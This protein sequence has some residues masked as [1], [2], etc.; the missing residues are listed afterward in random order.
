MGAHAPLVKDS[1]FLKTIADSNSRC[2]VVGRNSPS[3]GFGSHNFLAVV[4][5]I[6]KGWGD[7]KYILPGALTPGLLVFLT[8]I[9]FKITIQSLELV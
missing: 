8:L 6:P 2:L 1:I 3:H 5:F 7:A 4:W 9:R